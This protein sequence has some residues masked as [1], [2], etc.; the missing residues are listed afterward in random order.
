MGEI[1]NTTTRAVIYL[2]VPTHEWPS[3]TRTL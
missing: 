3:L 1:T 2:E